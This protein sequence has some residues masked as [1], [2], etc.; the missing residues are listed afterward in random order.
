MYYLVGKTSSE[1]KIYGSEGNTTEFL[2]F[3]Y[4]HSA[5]DKGFKIKG[6]HWGIRGFV[7][8][9]YPD[10]EQAEKIDQTIGCCRKLW[11][12]ML[13]EAIDLYKDTGEYYHFSE[14]IIKNRKEYE[15]M[16]DVDS[17]ALA[18]KS[19]DLQKAYKAFFDSVTGKRK[20]KV[21]YPNFKTK[22]ISKASYRSCSTNDNMRIEGDGK[23]RSLVMPMFNPS[24]KGIKRPLPIVVT[25][26]IN[27]NIKNITITKT[28]TGEYYASICCECWIGVIISDAEIH[29][30]LETIGIDGG[31]KTYMTVD[32]GVNFRKYNINDNVVLNNAL[33]KWNRKLVQAQQ[34]LSKMKKG[35]NNWVKQKQKISRYYEKIKRL[36]QWYR[37]NTTKELSENS[38]LICVENLGIKGMSSNPTHKESK[39]VVS[40]GFH[41]VALYETYRQL[42]YKQDWHNH[43]IVKVGRTFASSQLC[44]VCGYKN[45]EVSE[46]N[47]RAW[48]CP[49][50]GSKH[51]RDENASR[52]IRLEGIRLVN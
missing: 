39:K 22:H 13:A 2:S 5:L 15:Y 20:D 49:K 10:K 51:D 21:G 40:R 28:K 35:S 3:D 12:V 41:E 46:N 18:Q 24:G 26:P 11:N 30:K 37:H 31:I 34:R 16:K 19:R 32:D 33:D 4:V 8:R 47:L 45:K 7:C 48:L 23:Y 29:N 27:G 44:S 42:E 52:N 17:Q 9:I 14:K 1:Y 38:E 36:K 50:C 25:E 43:K 6:F